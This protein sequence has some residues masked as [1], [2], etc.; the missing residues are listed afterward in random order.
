MC[1]VYQ[2]FGTCG[3]RLPKTQRRCFMKVKALN[4]KALNVKILRWSLKTVKEAAQ[5][6]SG[7]VL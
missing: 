1:L 7:G 2:A 6:V 5:C 4:V 3:H